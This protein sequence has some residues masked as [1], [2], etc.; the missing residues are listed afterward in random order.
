M[1]LPL[2]IAALLLIA[3]CVDSSRERSP[4]HSQIGKN[5]IVYFRKDAL[6]MA[7]DVPASVVTGVL[8]GAEVT[9]SGELMEVGAVWIVI[10]FEGRIFHIPQASI[11]MVEFGQ[12]A[13]TRADLSE[14]RPA[15]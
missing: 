11:Q 1:R 9:Q 7:T 6:G 5:C 8:N 10:G 3:G 2:L 4:I 13:S 14:P 12:H 15:P